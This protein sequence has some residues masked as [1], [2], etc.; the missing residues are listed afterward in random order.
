MA[1]MSVWLQSCGMTSNA[2]S[3]PWRRTDSIISRL[4]AI[5]CAGAPYFGWMCEI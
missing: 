1:L 3:T 2:T 4:C 5:A